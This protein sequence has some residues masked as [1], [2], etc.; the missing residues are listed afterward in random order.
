MRIQIMTSWISSNEYHERHHLASYCILRLL[1]M[2]LL[3]FSSK[4]PSLSADL[5]HDEPISPRKL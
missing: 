5:L 2:L 3:H 1:N 4:N